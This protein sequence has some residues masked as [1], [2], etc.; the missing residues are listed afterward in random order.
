MQPKKQ[1]NDK[2]QKSFLKKWILIPLPLLLFWLLLT[3]RYVQNTSGFT[4][5]LYN[6]PKQEITQGKTTELLAGE[7]I[8]AEF[9]ARDNNLGIVAV[10]FNTFFRIN[11]DVVIFRIKEKGKKDWIATNSYTTPQFQ[12]NQYFTFGFPIQTDSQG[13]LYQYEIESTHGKRN[14][15]VALSPIE[16]IFVTKHQYLKGNILTDWQYL[17]TYLQRKTINTFSQ[18]DFILSFISYSLP[19]FIYFLR[20]LFFDKYLSK[21]YF[22]VLIPVEIMII[23]SLV[24]ITRN[25]GAVMGLTAFWIYLQLTYRLQSSYSFL[26]SGFFIVI[27]SI[28]YYSDKVE[29]ATNIAMWGFLFFISG[30]IIQLIE[31]IWKQKNLTPLPAFSSIFKLKK[32]ND[33]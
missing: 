3:F 15:S 16:P 14:N 9:T 24:N 11:E 13:K 29:L 12:P 26:M 6:H 5:L 20:M 33:N 31:I 7:K 1:K 19:F 23:L 30:V 18:F 10:R 4:V 8:K 22:I 27:T 17:I 32:R 28:L 25:D 21:K 2:P